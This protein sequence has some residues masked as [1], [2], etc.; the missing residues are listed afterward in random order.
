[1]TPTTHAIPRRL[2]ATLA[3]GGGGAEAIRRLRDAERSRTRLLIH[4][5]VQRAAAVRHPHAAVT[6]RAFD[7]LAEV[8]RDRSDVVAGLLSYPPVAA[9]AVHTV[10]ALHGPHHAAGNPAFLA[11]VTAVAAQRAG[12]ETVL[13]V[14]G[15][16]DGNRYL[17]LPG[18]GWFEAPASGSVRVHTGGS[19]DGEGLVVGGVAARL[20]DTD[21]VRAVHGSLRL[22][23]YL[24]V[25]AWHHA[26]GTRFCAVRGVVESGVDCGLWRD[27]LAAAWDLLGEHH[28]EIA[29]ELAEGLA[30]VV[31]LAAPPDR[32][33]SSSLAGAFGAVAM[34]VPPG[35]RGAALALVH[36]MQHSKFAALA[37]LYPL[38][39]EE[40]AT[41]Y[42]A[43][44]RPDP[45]PLTALL[46][47]TYAFVAV[48]RFWRTQRLVDTDASARYEAE[49][50][51]RRW[52]RAGHDVAAMLRQHPA[53][54]PMGTFLST[55]MLDVLRRWSG[56]P[57]SQQAAV[58]A[59]A[60]AEE[61]LSQWR[62]SHSRTSGPSSTSMLAE[63]PS[64]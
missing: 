22:E 20:H 46:D 53:L 44:W 25:A 12:A 29:R 42:Y 57:V 40:P 7:I 13:D 49:T 2:L 47:G 32:S 52:T 36:E 16:P 14:P 58:A 4:D 28:R 45:R 6:R 8:E 30:A 21:R 43:P 9:W 55:G 34:S 1:M 27:R 10:R 50:N 31:P 38:V 35:P 11:A 5:L 19:P 3:A 33:A 37:R 15:H 56:E 59:R 18:L 39:T 60:L 23:A 17:A 54:T 62:R 63:C 51:F 61:H 26:L 24:D 41:R 64:K 48:A